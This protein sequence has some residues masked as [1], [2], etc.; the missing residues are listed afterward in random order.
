MYTLAIIIISTHSCQ[1]VGVVSSHQRHGIRCPSE[2]VYLLVRV[3][4]EN[5]STGCLCHEVDD[6]WSEVLSLVY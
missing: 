2:A 5:L 1:I 3:S 4:N 6:G